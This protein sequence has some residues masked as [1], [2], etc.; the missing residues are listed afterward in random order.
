LNLPKL[1]SNRLLLALALT[2]LHQATDGQRQTT[3]PSERFSRAGNERQTTDGQSSNSQ[4]IAEQSSNSQ[5][6]E[7]SNP[8]PMFEQLSNLQTVIT[9]LFSGIN[10]NTIN[11]ELPQNNVTIKC[12]TSGMAWVYQQL[13]HLT[14]DIHFKEEMEYWL[15]LSFITETKN[16]AFQEADIENINRLG[17]LE[18][19]AGNLFLNEIFKQQ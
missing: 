14:G 10:R 18:G 8:Q 9:N 16:E 3:N 17:I 6:F 11:S 1:Q 13:H 4:A 7:Q 5:I 15:N 2:K 12:G 19:F